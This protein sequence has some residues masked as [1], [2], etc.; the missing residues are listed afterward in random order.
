MLSNNS[1]DRKN[2]SR[3]QLPILATDKDTLRLNA[4]LAER[5]SYETPDIS[6]LS[7]EWL[8]GRRKLDEVTRTNLG[9][10]SDA[11]I[12]APPAQAPEDSETAEIAPGQ[13]IP[14]IPEISYR[15][16]DGAHLWIGV[17]KGT[18]L[19]FDDD[20]QAIFMRLK[21]GV[22]PSTLAYEIQQKQNCEKAEA[23]APIVQV[24]TVLARHGFIRGIEGYVDEEIVDPSRFMRIHLTQ[25]CNLACVH[26]Y[27][28]SSPFADTSEQLSVER[29]KKL[30]DDFAANGG[31]RVLFTGGE[32]LMYHGCDELLRHSKSRGLYVTLFSNGILVEH[33]L[34]VIKETCDE[35]QISIDGTNPESNDPIRGGGS[36][37]RAVHATDL[38]VAAGVHV[39]IS[40]VVMEQNFE[41]IRD[42]YEDFVGRW[43]KHGVEFRL[44][45]GLTTHGRGE[46][47][48][49][50][51]DF[52]TARL[53]IDNL[54]TK[55]GKY[56]TPQIFRRN[57]GCGYAEQVVVNQDGNIH[58]CHLLDGA[59]T[60]V[61]DKPYGELLKSLKQN[62]SE[63]DVDHVLGCNLCDIRYLCGGECRVE[64]GKKTGNR[65][66]TSCQAEDKL[67]RLR[68][69]VR[70]YS[71]LAP[72]N[73]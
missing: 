61:D 70:A 51:L 25:R 46:D 16:I 13:P 27:A 49:N 62:I 8:N 30:I 65:R 40:T 5:A 9:V 41:A 34:D 48:Y 72:P 20:E 24:I 55:Y 63:Y 37:E 3:R 47:I 32:A 73:A 64:N 44:G 57:S 12:Q 45:N 68:G 14:L 69:L 56:A 42:G 11:N 22:I 19:V 71:R 21:E 15:F 31:E 58:P 66:V 1:V 2:R 29:W 54:E 17:D 26:C 6:M 10:V 38:L 33:Y 52:E 43:V 50:G 39:R 28:D 59:I 23:W 60:H 4:R 67:R 53:V 36:F 18:C 35:V 7:E